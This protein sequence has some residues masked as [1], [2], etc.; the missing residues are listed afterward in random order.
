MTGSHPGLRPQFPAS[1]KMAGYFVLLTLLASGT[2]AFAQTNVASTNSA[3]LNLPTLPM[4]NPLTSVL[5]VFGAFLLVTAIFFAGVWLFRNWRRF[6]VSRTG[7]PRLRVVE[8][9]SLGQRQAIYVVGYDQQRMLLASS[10][11]GIAFLSHLPSEE[12]TGAGNTATTAGGPS[13]GTTFAEAF[14]QV[15]SRKA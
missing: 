5:R 3:A 15:L 10:P 4:G 8:A 7:E 2:G 13:R 12:S 14:Q 6:T 1:I 11:A 9:K